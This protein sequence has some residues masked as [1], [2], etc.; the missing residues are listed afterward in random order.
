MDWVVEFFRTKAKSWK[1]LRNY[2]VETAQ[3]S[4][5]DDNGT[6]SPVASRGHNCYASKQEAL[7]LKFAE[8]AMDKF[9]RTKE[10]A[11]LTSAEK[12]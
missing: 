10:G 2:G 7:W 12:F 11:R 6:N 1:E 5:I 4:D 3:E 8:L 9:T